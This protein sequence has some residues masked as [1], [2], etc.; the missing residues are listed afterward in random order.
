MSEYTFRITDL[1]LQDRPRERLLAQGSRT[2]ANAELLAIL[3]GTGQG[4]GKLSALGLGQ[5]ILNQLSAY[6]GD[7]LSR[8]REIEAAE[9]LQIAGIGPAKAATILAALELGRRVYLARPPEGSL[10]DSPGAAAAVLSGEMMWA[11]QEHFAV[12]LLDIKNRLIGQH[13]VTKGLASETLSHPRETFRLAVRQG[14]SR[15]LIAHN[16]PSGDLEPS[17]SD[18][19]LTG[20][21]L[22]AGQI[23]GI[24]VLDHVILGGGH[25]TSLRERTQL[26]Q[27]YPQGD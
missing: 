21:L 2:L 9:L 17:P 27:D 19:H 11:S 24:P 7:P 26:W 1:P 4:P 18:L 13:I 5:L 8:L 15:I 6:D 16:H 14:A 3:L 25:F 22:Q 23:L 20:Q 12:V 10:I